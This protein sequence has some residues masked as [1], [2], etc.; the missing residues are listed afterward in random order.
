M[1]ERGIEIDDD[2]TEGQPSS[3]SVGLHLVVS[4]GVWLISRQTRTMS[5]F[6]DALSTMI[7]APPVTPDAP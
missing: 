6:V 4:D 7:S 5:N 2:L 1:S 3:G